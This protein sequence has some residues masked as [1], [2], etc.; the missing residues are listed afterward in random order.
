MNIDETFFSLR[1]WILMKLFLH[2]Y[3]Q[4]LEEQWM[5]SSLWI[6]LSR[7]EGY[8]STNYCTRMSRNLFNSN[9][10]PLFSSFPCKYSNYS[11]F[12]VFLS[13]VFLSICWLVIVRHVYRIFY[14]FFFFLKK[15]IFYMLVRP[16]MKQKADVPRLVWT[17][18]DYY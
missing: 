11:I 17:Q 2:F 6:V 3:R 8:Q 9:H 18:V 4:Y 12:S 13:H 5:E 16:F 10:P 1:E 15:G 7:L 14:M